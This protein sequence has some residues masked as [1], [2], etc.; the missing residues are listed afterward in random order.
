VKTLHLDLP[1]LSPDL[2]D[3]LSRGDAE[4][5]RAL[6]PFELPAAF[7]ADER[8][9]FSM[10]YEQARDPGWRPWL[11]RAIVLRE[12]SRMIG[13][14]NFHGPPGV[15]DTG[16]P[17]AVEIG[18]SIFPEFQ[19]RGFATEAA[20]ALLDHAHRDFGVIHFIAGILPTNA[21]SI[22]VIEKLGFARTEVVV[23][24]EVI[25]ELRLAPHRLA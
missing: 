21:P 14:T 1:L 19:G 25:F 17:D 2:L 3:A 13:Y 8:E 10:R 18:Y 15:N 20:R 12:Q 5:S 23:E 7:D 9:L 11:L 16:A 24:G 6:A 4:R 22:R